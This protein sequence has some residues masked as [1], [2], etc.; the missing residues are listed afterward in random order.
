MSTVMAVLDAGDHSVH[1]VQNFKF[2]ADFGTGDDFLGVAL[3]EYIDNRSSFDLVTM[4]NR[5]SLTRGFQITTH[6]LDTTTIEYR[7]RYQ[8]IGQF[9]RLGCDEC[10]K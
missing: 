2:Y 3:V 7:R 5:Q 1:F 8:V 4:S 9:E 10:T 6:H